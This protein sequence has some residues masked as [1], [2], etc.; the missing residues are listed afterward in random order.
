MSVIRLYKSTVSSE[1]ETYLERIRHTSCNETR[2]LLDTLQCRYMLIDR[3]LLNREH[4]SSYNMFL[5]V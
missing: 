3:T 5:Y 2:S 1:L 4:I